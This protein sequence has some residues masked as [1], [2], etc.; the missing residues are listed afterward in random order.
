MYR[1]K[2][3]NIYLN[4]GDQLTVNL[5]NK[6]DS[7]KIGDTLEFYVCAQGDYTNVVFQKHFDIDENTQTFGMDFTSEEMRIGNPIKGDP[8]IYWYEIEL[9]GRLTLVGYDNNGPKLFVLYPEAIGSGG[10]SI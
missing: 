5:V 1:I 2:N 10:G 6:K 9:N 7:F 3:K 4:R 8:K